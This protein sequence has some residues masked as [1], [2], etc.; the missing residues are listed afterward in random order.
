MA[1][2]LG[3]PGNGMAGNHGNVA[4]LSGQAAVKQQQLMEQQKQFLLGQRQQLIMAQQVNTPGQGSSTV[5]RI[6]V[7]DQGLG[8]AYPTLNPNDKIQREQTSWLIHMIGFN[9]PYY[10]VKSETGSLSVLP[11]CAC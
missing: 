11:D 8:A 2:Q 10:Y 6:W 7:L 9:L 4:Y 3:G 1:P 5:G